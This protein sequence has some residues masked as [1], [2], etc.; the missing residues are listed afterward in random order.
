MLF[1]YVELNPYS[2]DAE[3]P[4]LLYSFV[5]ILIAFLHFKP[6]RARFSAQKYFYKAT[7]MCMY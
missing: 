7:E 4:L 2:L 1:P 3:L 5:L 6:T